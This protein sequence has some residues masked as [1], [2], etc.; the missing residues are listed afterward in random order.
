MVGRDR[1]FTGNNA[2]SVYKC[3][4]CNH[5]W[6]EPDEAPAVSRPKRRSL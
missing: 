3:H 2:A 4:A 6:Q 5:T 1:E